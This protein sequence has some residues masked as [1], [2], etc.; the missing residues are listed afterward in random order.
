MLLLTP[1]QLAILTRIV[2]AHHRAFILENFGLTASGLT[3]ADVADLVASGVLTP[4]AASAI[5]G[6]DGIVEDAIGDA[7][8]T[9][10]ILARLREMQEQPQYQGEDLTLDK[11]QTE[12][13]REALPL[14]PVERKAIQAARNRAGEYC[15]GLGNTVDAELRTLAIE[16]DT[17]KAEKFRAEIREATGEA[18]ARRETISHLKSELG[19]RTQDWSRDLERIATTEL[20]NATCNGLADW[21]EKEADEG[22]D[23]EVYKLASKACKDCQR[24][25]MNEDGTPK[26]FKLSELRANGSNYG[27]KKAAWKATVEAIHPNCP[28]P[29]LHR[30]RGF[31]FEPRTNRLVPARRTPAAELADE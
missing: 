25:L 27:R 17:A 30:P 15:R 20:Q 3:P 2:E 31:T 11:V 16:A 5:V 12:L 18:I 26:V 1:A 13:E 7:W 10:M 22:E 19:H 8:I 29:L 24:L 21:I 23:P 14:G 4:Q 9:G 28:C 6:P